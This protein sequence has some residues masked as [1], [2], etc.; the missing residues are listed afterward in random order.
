MLGKV[1]GFVKKICTKQS[2]PNL[3][4]QKI[5]LLKLIIDSLFHSKYFLHHI[6]KK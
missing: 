2:V 5:L 4:K 1:P 3:E 6:R